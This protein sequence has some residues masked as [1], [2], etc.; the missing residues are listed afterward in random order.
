[1]VQQQR[2]LQHFLVYSGEGEMGIPMTLSI[3]ATMLAALHTQA[4][5]LGDTSFCI[6]S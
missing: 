6:V 5:S 1:M 3:N 2:K 4:F